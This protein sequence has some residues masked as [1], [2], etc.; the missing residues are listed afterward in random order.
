MR[1]FLTLVCVS[2]LSPDSAFQLHHHAAY[3]AP[4]WARGGQAKNEK[5]R[6]QGLTVQNNFPQ[7]NPRHIT[8]KTNV[9]PK[10][11]VWERLSTGGQ[12]GGR[13]NNIFLFSQFSFLE[14]KHL[15]FQLLRRVLSLSL[16]CILSFFG[17]YLLLDPW[18]S[19]CNLFFFSLKFLHPFPGKFNLSC[20]SDLGV[21]VNTGFR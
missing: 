20:L 16:V 5:E 18:K 1:E 6:N 21:R 15:P 3:V 10:D 13:E 4:L 17:P 14:K 19:F 7:L 2:V 11:S 8:L 12:D 9:L